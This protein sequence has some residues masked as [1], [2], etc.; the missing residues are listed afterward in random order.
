[1]ADDSAE[2]RKHLVRVNI[3]QARIFRLRRQA[4][5]HPEPQAEDRLLESA[6]RLTR[7]LLNEHRLPQQPDLFGGR[8]A[9]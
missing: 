9:A 3:A 4:T 5:G 2:F 7:G 8:A 1:M 6:I